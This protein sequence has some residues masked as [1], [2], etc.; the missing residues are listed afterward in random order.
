MTHEATT[1]ERR[2]PDGLRWQVRRLG[3]G[4]AAITADA[5]PSA[6]LT[7]RLRALRDALWEAR[8]RSVADLVPGYR[9]LLA[10]FRAGADADEVARWLA[11]PRTHAEGVTPPRSERISV[12]Y[13]D[14]ADR[15]AL[16]RI[17]GLP[18]A[19]IVERHA[20]ATYT[21]AFIGFTPGFPY[22]HG[23]PAALAAPRRERPAALV[24]A[25]AVA[26]ADGQ[27]GIYPSAS[28]GGWWVL[29]TTDARLFDPRRSPP[30][31]LA[32]GDEVRF[33][34]EETG[35][36]PT[37]AGRAPPLGTQ[38]ASEQAVLVIDDV[39][40]GAATLQARPRWGVGHHGM[41]QAGALDAA[42]RDAAQ[43]IVGAP[44]DSPA[45][46][47]IVPHL[48][49]RCL[50]ATRLAVTGGGVRVWLDGREQP[51]WR[52]LTC[53]PGSE[54]TLTPAAP[55]AAGTSYLAIAGGIAWPWDEHVQDDLRR[56]ASSDVRAGVGRA[57]HAGDTLW[58]AGPG[59]APRPWI[60][61]PRYGGRVYLRIHPGPQATAPALEALTGR[62]WRLRTRDRT[63]ARLEGPQLALE[64]HD[65]RSEGVPWGAV[66]VPGDGQP[67]VLLS[68][69]GRT[70]GYAAPAIV[71][72]RDLWQLAQAG[73]GS[74]VWFLRPDWRH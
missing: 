23:L 15:E 43:E 25:G 66:Q 17:T 4:A 13:G 33:V 5:T 53:T 7:L 60:G 69:R 42:A 63:A 57:L 73:P 51:T 45:L 49:L 61:R 47:L 30:A 32:A 64:R 26:I 11:R 67:L 29:G 3:T 71:D 55:Q 68:D 54:L 70:G 41:A 19:T 35:A 1:A 72:P 74:E 12:R 58:P 46:E 65:V 24:P 2:D 36:P 44:R 28:P 38:L 52:A 20:A 21:V 50:R 59:G 9:G 39:W 37:I 48:R 22:L 56:S 6:E 34:A 40:A 62:S 10:E 27:A 18:W 8:P 16:E 31:L 14:R